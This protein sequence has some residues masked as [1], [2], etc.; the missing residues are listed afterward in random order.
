M[1]LVRFYVLFFAYPLG[2]TVRYHIETEHYIIQFTSQSYDILRS[3]IFCC[4]YIY[5]YCTEQNSNPTPCIY[6]NSISCMY[7][8][9]SEIRQKFLHIDGPLKKTF[10]KRTPEN[11]KIS[12]TRVYITRRQRH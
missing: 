4:I 6:L 8:Y 9:L 11:E 7:S 5:T 1:G 3:I 10:P 12:A 2:L